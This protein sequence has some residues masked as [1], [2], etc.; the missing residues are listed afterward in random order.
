[1]EKENSVDT[2]SYLVQY[3]D[4]VGNPTH[5][6]YYS[7]EEIKKHLSEENFTTLERNRMVGIQA[8]ESWK[9]NYGIDNYTVRI[10]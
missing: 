4:E 3:Y 2:R 8:P 1:M 6:S 5:I 10:I 7:E 9:K